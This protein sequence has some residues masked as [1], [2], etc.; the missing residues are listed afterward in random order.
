MDDLREFLEEEV[1]RRFTR[2][3][4]DPGSE[5][6]IPV[7]PQSAKDLGYDPGEVD[8][9]PPEAA[10]LFTGV[11]N[12]LSLGAWEAGWTVLDVGS[13]AGLDSLLVARRIGDGG[14]RHR[15]GHDAVDDREGPG[16]RAHRRCEERGVS[17]GP[18]G[19]AAG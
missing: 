17:S 4:D 12:A 15:R 5:R 16:G 7:G 13:G 6:R 9:L 3:A 14:A 8:A 19:C 11:G 2:F 10:S 18:S 1:I